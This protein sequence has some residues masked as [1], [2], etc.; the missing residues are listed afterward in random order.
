MPGVERFERWTAAAVAG[1]ASQVARTYLSDHH[2]A[3]P[4]NGYAAAALVSLVPR[5][6]LALCAAFAD[7]AQTSATICARVYPGD[8]A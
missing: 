7:G 4:G 3:H 1:D 8:Q 6:D 5:Q 2:A